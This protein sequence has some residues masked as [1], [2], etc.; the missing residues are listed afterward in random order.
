MGD[1]AQFCFAARAP[2]NGQIC[3]FHKFKIGQI[4]PITQKI[5]EEAEGA[6]KGR[7]K[8]VRGPAIDSC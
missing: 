2:K 6:A 8:K 4:L 7:E 3:P 1:F 5:G